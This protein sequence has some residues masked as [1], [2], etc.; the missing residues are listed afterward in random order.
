MPEHRPITVTR[1][2][3]LARRH[4]RLLAAAAAAASIATLGFSL[5][6]PAEPTRAVVVAAT[7]LP[8]GRTL[9][10]DD[11]AVAD[12]PAGIL[13]A[14]THPEPR[15]LI[16]RVLAAPLTRGEAV[17]DHRLT[18]PP[19]WSLPP[20]TM[21]LP[22]RFSDARAAALLTAGQH[23]DVLASGGHGL[24]ETASPAAGLVAERALVLAV[25]TDHEDGGMLGA[26]GSED[27]ALVLLAVDR[28]T[29]QAISGAQGRGELGYVMH[30]SP[31]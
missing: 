17:G 27:P 15:A 7:D 21:P 6:P 3:R 28:A 12:V 2:G 5:Q 25:V 16:G 1:A 8:S 20:G 24:G 19:Q 11:L 30:P 26:R 14:G 31:S 18:A 22:V 9:S 10:P 29:A 4:R 23:V 13:P